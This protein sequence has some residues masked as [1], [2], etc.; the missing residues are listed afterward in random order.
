MC[1]NAFPQSFPIRQ[2]RK[3][4]LPFKDFHLSFP[5]LAHSFSSPRK[6]ARRSCPSCLKKGIKK[7]RPRLRPTPIHAFQGGPNL[8]RPG[9][10]ATRFDHI[11][12][13]DKA[14][15]SGL[16]RFHS[17]EA[18]TN[19]ANFS[20]TQPRSISFFLRLISKTRRRPSVRFRP[21]DRF[22]SHLSDPTRRRRASS[23]PTRRTS[24]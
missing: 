15:K 9:T 16:V 7:C 8:L 19:A 14:T 24:P 4:S 22:H 6:A 11:S 23:R 17:P 3:G 1:A 2:P 20:C 5:N 10:K 21:G 12:S 13:M 18:R